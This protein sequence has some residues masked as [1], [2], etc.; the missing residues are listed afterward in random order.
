MKI[1][2]LLPGFI[3]NYENLNIINKFIK[4]NEQYKIDIYFATYDIVGLT[5]KETEDQSVYKNK[6]EKTSVKNIDQKL[7]YPYKIA[8][9]SYEKINAEIENLI[10][11][12]NWDIPEPTNNNVKIYPTLKRIF[13]QWYMV[14]KCFDLMESTKIKYDFIIKAR[15]DLKMQHFDLK[16]LLNKNNIK[17]ISKNYIAALKIDQYTVSDWILLGNHNSMKKLS[18]LGDINIFHKANHNKHFKS[19]DS[20][21]V[22]QKGKSVMLSSEKTISHWLFVQNNFEL[23]PIKNRKKRGFMINRNIKHYRPQDYSIDLVMFDLDGVLV[24]AC[25]WHKDALND[26]LKS[27]YDYSISEEDHKKTFNG[28]PTRTKL[29]I[30]TERNIISPL[31]HEKIYQLKQ[32][33]TIEKIKKLSFVRNEKIE[34]LKYLKSKNCKI[35]CVTNSIKETA[36]LML[37]T[38]G[39]INMFDLIITNQDVTNPKPNPEG[40]LKALKHFNI[41]PNKAIIIEDS[42]KGLEAAYASKCKVLKVN[43]PNDVNLTLLKELI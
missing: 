14:K 22:K 25:E 42:P 8:L 12:K 20:F 16:N 2:L 5:C 4:K 18:M 9:N 17:K 13:S 37:S 29:K 1:A 21:F 33:K 23:L 27:F 19:Y 3:R 39:I 6:S 41:N 43:N 34:L 35:V 15:P 7:L 26:A 38:A 40:Y 24:D 31:D 10:S 30:L 36:Q 28:I 11:E 32:K